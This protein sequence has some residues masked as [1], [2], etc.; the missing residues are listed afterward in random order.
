MIDNLHNKYIFKK[1]ERGEKERARA[2]N[3][4]AIIFRSQLSSSQQHRTDLNMTHCYCSCYCICCHRVKTHVRLQSLE[5]CRAYAILYATPHAGLKRA[6]RSSISN[7]FP[8][9]SLNNTLISTCLWTA[10]WTSNRVGELPSAATARKILSDQSRSSRKI[11][12]LP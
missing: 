12:R 6:V 4:N 1:R 7:D 8:Q 11:S 10:P 3:Y 5:N 9:P 2:Q